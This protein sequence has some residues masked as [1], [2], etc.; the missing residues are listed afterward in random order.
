MSRLLHLDEGA[1][2]AG[3]WTL[4]QLLGV[5]HSRIRAPVLSSVRTVTGGSTI[6]PRCI[7]G[8]VCATEATDPVKGLLRLWL[9]KWKDAPVPSSSRGRKI[10]RNGGWGERTLRGKR[11]AS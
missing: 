9:M 4:T 2:V 10:G 5:R 11:G 7:A 6:G 3:S 1:I 8:F